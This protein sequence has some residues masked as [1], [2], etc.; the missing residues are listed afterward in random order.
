AQTTPLH[1]S[2]HRRA[3]LIQNIHRGHYKLGAEET[4]NLRILAAF[5]ELAL[6]I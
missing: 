4:V 3:R 6:V 5:D 2:N 1:T